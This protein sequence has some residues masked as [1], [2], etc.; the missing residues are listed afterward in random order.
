MC[1]AVGEGDHRERCPREADRSRCERS[2][3]VVVDDLAALAGAPGTAAH[4]EGHDVGQRRRTG[5]TPPVGRSGPKTR[6]SGRA[7]SRPGC[8]AASSSAAR[9][10]PGRRRPTARQGSTT[11]GSP[12][13]IGSQN[14]ALDHQTLV[15]AGMQLGI[16]GNGPRNLSSHVRPGLAV[17]RPR[18]RRR[19]RH[20]R[21]LRR[22][23]PRPRGLERRRAARARPPHVRHD[24]ARG[25]PDRHVRL[26]VRDVDRDAQVHAR[27]LRATSRPRPARRPASSRSGSSRS[28]PTPIGSRSTGAS[29][30]STATAASTCTR[31]R[32]R[33]RRTCSRSPS[34]DD[35][36][37]G[38]YVEGGRPREPGR[39]HDG[40]REGRAH[41]GRDDHRGRAA[42]PASCT[43][44]RR[45]HRRATP[46]T[47]T[48]RRVRRE[49][50]RHVGAPA[51]RAARA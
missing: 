13:C 33:G 42:S 12:R 35:I 30:R 28:Q 47:A 26:D 17:P 20:H 51:R 31:S 10:S 6:G 5:R 46:R 22:V 1:C 44:R 36:L 2:E 15:G 23:P 19:R 14:P 21:L 27:P 48:S 38:F 24:V 4:R 39:R 16:R 43:K 40:A 9:G 18:R 50:R 3:P 29:P 7:T 34:T 32:R 37:A 25:R 41:A 11:C 45:G 8:R 49:L